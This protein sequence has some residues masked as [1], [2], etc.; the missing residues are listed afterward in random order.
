MKVSGVKTHEEDCGVSGICFCLLQDAFSLLAYSDPWN[1]PVGYQ[2]DA[3]QR[4]PVC[5]TLN[6][7]ILGRFYVNVPQ[8]RLFSAMKFY[9]CIALLLVFVGV[10][11]FAPQIKHLLYLC[12]Y[13]NVRLMP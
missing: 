1:S 13:R 3:I 5:S 9:L 6:S 12:C 11:H 8:K 4:E 7:A 2:L 10:S